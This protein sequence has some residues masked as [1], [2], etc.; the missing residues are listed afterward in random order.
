MYTALGYAPPA[1]PTA[2]GNKL[3]SISAGLVR[4]TANSY[5]CSSCLRCF[6]ALAAWFT[7]TRTTHALNRQTDWVRQD[8]DSTDNDDPWEELSVPL[9]PSIPRFSA[10]FPFVPEPPPD[11]VADCAP[12]DSFRH[13]KRNTS[14]LQSL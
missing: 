10:V 2:D 1:A 4:A 12:A 9:L 5:C 6:V 8:D 14:E 7:T 3:L 11:R 13:G